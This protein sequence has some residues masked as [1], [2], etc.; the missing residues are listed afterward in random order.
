MNELGKSLQETLDTVLEEAMSR[1]LIHDIYRPVKER[2]DITAVLSG[3]AGSQGFDSGTKSNLTRFPLIVHP[4]PMTMFYL[5]PQLFRYLHRQALSNAFKYGQTGGNV[6]TEL[7]CDIDKKL[8]YMSVINLP[9]DFHDK[10]V[11]G[12]S[13]MEGDVFK[14]GTQIHE[15]FRSEA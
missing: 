14:K 6:L 10:L 7:F 8:L 11:A 5:D 4:C 13:K 9:G 3:L 15:G 12:G 2:V 1:D